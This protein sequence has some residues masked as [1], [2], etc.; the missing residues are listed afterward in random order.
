MKTV[1]NMSPNDIIHGK[2]LENRHTQSSIPQHLVATVAISVTRFGIKE[3][4][5]RK[6]G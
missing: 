1:P 6:Q 4:E 2:C 5:E 3:E